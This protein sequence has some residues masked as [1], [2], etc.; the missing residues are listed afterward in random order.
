MKK[1]IIIVD[2]HE[3]CQNCP[4]LIRS[5]RL[6]TGLC[7]VWENL[8]EQMHIIPPDF[9]KPEW[10]LIKEIPVKRTPSPGD[11]YTDGWNDCIDKITED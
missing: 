8:N 6:K 5:M 4:F 2:V 11:N 7:A 3:T 10:C 1:G 9:Q